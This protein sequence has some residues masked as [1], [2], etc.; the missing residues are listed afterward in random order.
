[1]LRYYLAALLLAMAAGQLLSLQEFVAIIETYRFGPP[2]L[3]WPLAL[4]I[5]GSE[6][7]GGAGLLGPHTRRTAA[8][9]VTLAVAVAWT[10]LAVQAFVRGLDVQNCGCFGAYLGQE[11]RWYVLVQDALFVAAAAW[12]WI[13]TA[14]ATRSMPGLRVNHAAP[15]AGTHAG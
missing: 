2:Q 8:S 3:A 6:L 7:A 10:L 11:L 15:Q 1:M 13:R 5:I 12:L 14:R 4:A 9:T